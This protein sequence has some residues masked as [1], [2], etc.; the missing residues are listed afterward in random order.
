[1]GR[2]KNIVH[3]LLYQRL[4]KR[5]GGF[6]K[7]KLVHFLEVI[8]IVYFYQRLRKEVKKGVYLWEEIV[9]YLEVMQ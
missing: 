7:K 9:H 8:S 1:M 3:Y 6:Q 5:I 4:R 2:R